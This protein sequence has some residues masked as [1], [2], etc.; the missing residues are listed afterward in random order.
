MWEHVD[1]E[2]GSR[3]VADDALLCGRT[4]KPV[5]NAHYLVQHV[6][7]GSTLIADEKSQEGSK[8]GNGF[9]HVLGILPAVGS[10]AIV[11]HTRLRWVQAYG[12]GESG[13]TSKML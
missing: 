9:F 11:D 1:G 4:W 10:K 13:A 2:P 8:G 5:P 7:C 12:E 3:F 6:L